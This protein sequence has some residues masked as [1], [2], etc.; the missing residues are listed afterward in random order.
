[1][2]ILSLAL[3]QPDLADKVLPTQ[4]R[5]MLYEKQHPLKECYKTSGQFWRAIVGK[6]QAKNIV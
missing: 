5:C 2:N 1:M 6:E 3:R 4:G